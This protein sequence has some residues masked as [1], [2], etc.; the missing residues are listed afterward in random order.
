MKNSNLVF[1]Q[2]LVELF[3]YPFKV[4]YDV[5]ACIIYVAGI[6]TY[7]Q[8]IIVFHPII[9]SGQLFKAAAD[10]RT[11]ARH[12]LQCYIAGSVRCQYRIQSLDDLA[13]PGFGTGADMCA[14]MKDEN[15]AAHGN[16]AFQ[17]QSQEIHSKGIGL[18]IHRIPQV[19]NIRGMDD[20]ILNSILLHIFP[21]SI[22]IQF[23]YGLTFCILGRA[24]IHHESIGSIRDSLLGRIQQHILSAHFYMR[25]YFYHIKT[26][27]VYRY[28]LFIYLFAFYKGIPCLFFFSDKEIKTVFLRQQVSISQV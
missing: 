25:S 7:P 26:P 21:G 6:K 14:R 2:F 13:Q 17:L 4:I 1:S 18:R 3:H 10:F 8:F 15:P 5:I 28:Y 11:L 22:Y 19:D 24:G 16:G 27:V 20:K 9:N 23:T 12:G